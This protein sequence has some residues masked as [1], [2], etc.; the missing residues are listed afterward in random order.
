MNIER[1]YFLEKS[2][3]HRLETIER[4]KAFDIPLLPDLNINL[5]VEHGI[6]RVESVENFDTELIDR[7]EFIKEYTV[8]LKMAMD[9]PLKSFCYQRLKYLESKFQMHRLLNEMRESSAISS[10][11]HRDFYNVRKVDTHLHAASCMNQ[12]HLLSFMKKKLS[13]CA[14]VPVYKDNS[15]RVMTLREVFD[16]LEISSEGL[17]VDMLGVHAV[18]IH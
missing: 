7:Q 14:T 9:G 3:S 6:Y 13:S 10:I 5:T 4:E 1:C 11:L 8:L 18:K 12:K 2:E 17:N 16:Q 15:G